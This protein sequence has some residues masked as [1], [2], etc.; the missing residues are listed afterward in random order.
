MREK[1]MM[2]TREDEGRP[3]N[4]RREIVASGS[5]AD[6]FGS[7]F[8]I[9]YDK[10]LEGCL[11][12]WRKKTEDYAMAL[13]VGKR[14]VEP[15]RFPGVARLYMVRSDFAS[16]IEEWQPYQSDVFEMFVNA[17]II[18]I[19][20]SDSDMCLEHVM[21]DGGWVEVPDEM[22]VL[23][24][25]GSGKSTLL[26]IAVASFLKNI[27]NYSAMVYSGLKEKSVDLLNSICA[28]FE[29]MRFRDENFRDSARVIR[30]KESITVYV[31]DDDIRQINCSSSFGMVS[32]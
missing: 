21:K 26:S 17:N 10:P 30:L 12:F 9:S 2:R 25:R 6:A 1:K 15:A 13:I 24:S 29:G 22:L 18:N 19:L 8:M 27:P 28:A 14:H 4:K 31:S 5:F 11:K 7:R 20:G 3:P 32:P 16:A 23:A